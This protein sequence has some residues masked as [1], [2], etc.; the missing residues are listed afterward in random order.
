MDQAAGR[1]APARFIRAV[2][3]KHAA[4]LFDCQVMPAREILDVLLGHPN[5]TRQATDAFRQMSLRIVASAPPS[6]SHFAPLT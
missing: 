5:R 1:V 3:V 4:G 2:F 6:I